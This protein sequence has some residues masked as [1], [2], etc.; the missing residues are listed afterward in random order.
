MVRVKSIRR[1]L[2]LGAV[3]LLGFGLGRLYPVLERPPL[4]L[5]QDAAVTGIAAAE[6]PIVF[7]SEA[8]GFLDVASSEYDTLFIFYPGGLVR[9]QAYTWLGVALAPYGVRTIIPVFSFDLA[10]TAPNR[11]ETLLEV[12]APSLPDDTRVVLG[13]HSLGGAMA[14]RFLFRQPDAADALVLM[15]AFSAQGDDLSALPIDALV[16]AAEHDGLATLPEVRS[17]LVR[18]PPDAELMVL[19]GA[20]HSFFGRYGP[21]RGDGEPTVTRAEAEAQTAQALAVFFTRVREQVQ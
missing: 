21:Q 5:L 12:L 13:G 18:L 6:A 2:V 4:I 15:G 17:G 11:A 14:A 7:R 10:V 8:G 1:A 3:L 19:A 16:L 20:V 9:P